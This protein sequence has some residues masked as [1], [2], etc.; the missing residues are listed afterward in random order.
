MNIVSLQSAVAYGHVGNSAAVFPMQRL[1]HEVWPVHTVNFSNH[2]EYPTWRGPVLGADNVREIL[3]GMEFAFP[4]VDLFVSGYLGTAEM[5]EVV[6]DAVVAIKEANP[7]ARYVC[8]PV[9]GNSEVGSFVNE[10]IPDVYTETLIPLADA[11]TP[12]QWELSLLTGRR[13]DQAGSTSE[14]AYAAD[15]AAAEYTEALADAARSLCSNAL[16]TSVETGDPE[17]IGMVDVA[18]TSVLRTDAPRLGGNIVGAG[19]LATALYAALIDVA[20]QQRLDHLAGTMG[21]MVR[22]VRERG[23]DELPLVEL[24]ECIVDPARTA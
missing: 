17:T 3:R 12:N 1:G 23:L 8:D 6:R 15:A 14:A 16:I 18:S 7:Q 20:P 11:I 4:Q 24:Q 10:D 13:L 22:A 21:A 9:I 5:A 2:T 19:D